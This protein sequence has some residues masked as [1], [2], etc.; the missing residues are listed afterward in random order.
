MHMRKRHLHFAVEPVVMM[1]LF[2]KI[3][4]ASAATAAPRTQYIK[5]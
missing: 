3:N 2:V 4:H 1:S 5:P